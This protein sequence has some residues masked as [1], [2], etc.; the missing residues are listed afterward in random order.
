M[1]LKAS[2]PKVTDEPYEVTVT[3]GTSAVT[4]RVRLSHTP[5]A[6]DS[7]GDFERFEDLASKLVGVP[8]AEVD[9]KREKS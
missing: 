4:E 7:D 1:T 8:K 9:A 6:S 5:A 2:W 3:P